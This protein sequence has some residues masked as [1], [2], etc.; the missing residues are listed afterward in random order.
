MTSQPPAILFLSKTTDWCQA[1]QR[2]VLAHFRDVTI[3]EG[4]GDTPFPGT[5]KNWQGDYIISFLSPWVIPE[6]VLASARNAAINF[7]PAPPEYPGIGCYN[8]ALYEE[9]KEYGVTCHHMAKKVD[10]GA[11]LKVVRF[12]IFPT[13]SVA[14]LRDRSMA[15]L[16]T[17]F[18]EVATLAAQGVELPMSPE[19]WRRQPYKRK[20]LDALCRITIDMSEDEI[21]RR[22]RATLYPGSPG[23]EVKLA[24]YRFTI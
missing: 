20:E 19:V 18:Y 7:H 14:S 12:P 9:A 15:Y 5:A 22:V 13:D 1:A 24:G 2:F 6:E 21:R 16:L 3:F 8:F 23:P 4:E 17:L 10:S 11:I